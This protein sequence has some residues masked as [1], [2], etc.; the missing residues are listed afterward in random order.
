[1]GIDIYTDST[2]MKGNT[3][4]Y[5]ELVIS[6]TYV[7]IIMVYRAQFNLGCIWDT[8]PSTQPPESCQTP[9]LGLF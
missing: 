3:I 4:K 7:V 5:F 8:I 6:L 2:T 1:M 9:F